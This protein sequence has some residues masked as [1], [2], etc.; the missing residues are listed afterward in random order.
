[1]A[2][3]QLSS[4][5]RAGVERAGRQS[6]SVQAEM[7]ACVHESPWRAGEAEAKK[8]RF[9]AR[10]QSPLSLLHHAGSMQYKQPT[11]RAALHVIMKACL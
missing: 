6:L 5:W 2:K 9:R 3:G 11:F 8:V 4:E 7:F 1:M 10:H